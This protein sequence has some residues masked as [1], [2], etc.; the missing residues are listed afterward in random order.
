MIRR[1]LPAVILAASAV[2]P[3]TLVAGGW[4][5]VTVDSLPDSMV[6]GRPTAITFVVRQHGTRPV[7]GLSPAVRAV[8]GDETVAADALPSGSP[9]RY[10]ARFTVPRPGSWT[11]TIASGFGQSR[12][13]LLPIRA[14]HAGENASGR[15]DGA[16]GV[17]AARGER[18]FVA[19]GC[20]TCHQSD[21]S[22]ENTSVAA[23][24]RLVPQ[25]YQPEFLARI[26]ADPAANLPPS[27]APVGAMPD[28][29][30]SRAE[31]ASLV[32]FITTPRAAAAR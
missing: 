32:A 7:D 23:G 30:L 2:V 28:L 5:V 8:L 25:K 10:T 9:G 29:Q 20:V 27:R 18:L 26:L 12:L 21:I 6:V 14:A 4:A 1:V 17:S 24:P 22:P 15:A 13:T 19:K 31:I 3:V 11:I 16:H